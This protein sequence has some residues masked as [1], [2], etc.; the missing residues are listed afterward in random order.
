MSRLF[1]TVA[2]IFASAV[3][4]WADD[5]NT[6]QWKGDMTPG[7]TLAIRAINGGIAA[8]LAPG[9]TAQVTAV[10]KGVRDDPAQVVVR[11]IDT[12]T[13]ILICVVYPNG[14][15]TC[16]GGSMSSYSN[17]VQVQ[18]T[19]HVPGGVLL[20]ATTINGDIRAMGLTANITATTVNGQISLS[21]TAAATA[22][23]VNGSIVAA[24]GSTD[25]PSP[26]RFTTVNGSID[27]TIP[28]AANTVVHAAT[29]YGTVAT[30]FP[31][32]VRGPSGSMCS[33]SIGSTLNGTIGS[34][35]S[36][37]DLTTVNGSIHLRQ[38]Q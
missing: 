31:L 17:D 33:S 10:K 34:G 36:V 32:Q 2:L 28:A 8:D 12:D 9:S 3:L 15:D 23:T 30:D 37:L 7:Q 13:G 1:T 26:S 21:T 4:T 22:T 29:V 18:F 14:L 25:W 16:G 6:F 20:N 38:G 11:E 19:V 5:T 27:T 35:G 24:L